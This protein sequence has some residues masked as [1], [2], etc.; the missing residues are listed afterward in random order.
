[1]FLGLILAVALGG[2]P[3]AAAPPPAAP[4]PAAETV[5]AKRM[6]RI[7][8]MASRPSKLDVTLPE[9]TFRVEVKGRSYYTDI[10]FKWDFST[11]NATFKTPGGVVPGV[12]PSGTP[13]LYTISLIPIIGAFRKARSEKA[14]K[15]AREEVQRALA[16]FC[17]AHACQ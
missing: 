13:P 2:D 11:G 3:Q 12:G 5:E 1:M 15:D 7:G 8:E 14:E 16:E 4:P 6:A 17:A 10:P 9:P